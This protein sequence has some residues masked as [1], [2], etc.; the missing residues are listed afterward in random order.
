MKNELA[1]EMREHGNAIRKTLKEFEDSWDII[2]DLEQD[3]YLAALESDFDEKSKLVTW[4]CAIAKNV[5]RM[6]VRAAS[7]EKRAREVGEVYIEGD[8]DEAGYATPYYD[9]GDLSLELAE[10]QELLDPYYQ[11]EAEQAAEYAFDKLP[12]AARYPMRLRAEGYS[13]AEIAEMLDLSVSYVE[14]LISRARKL[15]RD[16]ENLE[17]NATNNICER[18][19]APVERYATQAD[20][21]RAC[22]ERFGRRDSAFCKRRVRQANPDATL[23]EWKEAYDG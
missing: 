16:G 18:D 23:A 11:Y 1:T 2:D 20:V 8:Y 12:G 22:A 15:L 4:L 13:N 7:A 5:G 6:H 17:V 10:R 3:V 19:V 9:R 21:E 14:N